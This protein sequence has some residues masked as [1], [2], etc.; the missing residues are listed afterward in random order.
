M[1]GLPTS[2]K[3]GEIFMRKIL[4]IL[5]VVSIAITILPISTVYAVSN[6]DILY[7]FEGFAGGTPTQDSTTLTWMGYDEAHEEPWTSAN[8][9]K[10][11]TWL[12][13]G[14]RTGSPSG[15]T[16]RIVTRD[17]TTSYNANNRY[18]FMSRPKQHVVSTTY[19]EVWFSFDWMVEDHNAEHSMRAYLQV[20]GGANEQKQLFT[21]GTN[22][23]L[24]T[25]AGSTDVTI[26][27]GSWHTYEMCMSS[28]EGVMFYLDGQLLNSV[29][30]VYTTQANWMFMQ[31]LNRN[32][33][34]RYKGSAMQIDDYR[35]TSYKTPQNKRLWGVTNEAFSESEDGITFSGIP[36]NRTGSPKSYFI[37]LN[38][39]DE[40]GNYVTYNSASG[41]QASGTATSPVTVTVSQWGEDYTA[42]AYV[43]N[44]VTDRTLFCDEIYHR[45]I[46]TK[47][48]VFLYK[49]FDAA[50]GGLNGF[51]IAAATGGK[52][53]ETGTESY[54][55]LSAASEKYA[56]DV[57]FSGA[58]DKLVFEAMVK[59]ENSGTNLEF[60]YVDSA[61]AFDCF[62]TVNANGSVKAG[63]TTVG[64]LRSGEW[65]RISIAT[66]FS[67]HQMTAWLNGGQVATDIGRALNNQKPIKIRIHRPES[68]TGGK[69]SIDN[70]RIYSGNSVVRVPEASNETISILG[71]DTVARS[72][73][74]GKQA[75][76]AYSSNIVVNGVKK[77]S[78]TPAFM[79]DGIIYVGQD[80]LSQ[81]LDVGLIGYPGSDVVRVSSTLMLMPHTAIE[82]DGEIYLPARELAE[83]LNRKTLQ[84]E[85]GVLLIS[86]NAFTMD[87]TTLQEVNDYMQYGRLTPDE[88]LALLSE[89]TA[90]PRTI[91]SAE[92]VGVIRNAYQTRDA[93]FMT[94]YRN[95][96]K[97]LFFSDRAV[98]ENTATSSIFWYTIS[99]ISGWLSSRDRTMKAKIWD[100]VEILCNQS[101]WDVEN[102]SLGRAH[103]TIVVAMAYDLLYDQWDDTQRKLMEDCIIEY[104]LK[105]VK[106]V[107]E[108]DNPNLTNVFAQGN[109]INAICA[110]AAIIGAAAV[111]DKAPELSSYV[112]AESMHGLERV[113]NNFYPH[114]GWG[115]GAD[116]AAYMMS[117]LPLG[118]STIENSLGHDYGFL[119][120]PGVKEQALFAI[121]TTGNCGANNY[122]DGSDWS[123]YQ[124][125]DGVSIA[126][127]AHTFESPEYYQLRKDYRNLIGVVTHPQD[128]LYYHPE[129]EN[130]AVTVENPLDSYFADSEFF[131]MRSD[132]TKEGTYLSGHFGAESVSHSHYDNGTFVL[133]MLGERWAIDLGKDDYNLPGYFVTGTRDLY[134][135]VRPEGHNTVV[136]GP[137]SSLG[138]SYHGF[139]KILQHA[140]SSDGAFVVGD[141]TSVYENA[142]SAKRGFMLTDN[143]SSVIIRDEIQTKNACDIYWF[144]HT[145]ADIEIVDS[146]TA[147]LTKNGKQITLSFITNVQNAV[148]SEMEAVPLSTSPNPDGQMKNEG[149]SKIAIRIPSAEDVD[150]TVRITPVG[151]TA[152][153]M[154]ILDIPLEQWT[155][156]K[157]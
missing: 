34:G 40:A 93:K 36:F 149:V 83:M 54:Y 46:Q 30:T 15:T 9:N 56:A 152:E 18:V 110:S 117:L 76:H 38:V 111:W 6:T 24:S 150:L 121:A 42:K 144:M 63:K 103:S 32:Y 112:M 131:S 100:A 123:T 133:D 114:G 109:N 3:I 155:V 151:S 96:L 72:N 79:E 130:N 41:T 125:N 94:L 99:F 122:H 95:G 70:L 128:I 74:I 66:D 69:V 7:D 62:L 61:N 127:A 8:L 65:N 22:G 78:L 52:L 84:G 21:I 132:Y 17:N 39:Y 35:V 58:T 81:M 116:Y 51:Q 37:V 55:E 29:S 88:V 113:Q 153:N 124:A 135:R 134:Y 10:S 102:D 44:S 20:S 137:D 14:V 129:W 118:L 154:D 77:T 142:T 80:D 139:G 71:N 5:L 91:L 87:T 12:E 107:L 119:T 147:I 97:N 28:T 25:L 68:T 59:Q 145:S 45:N 106:E 67:S 50:T 101:S 104:G 92:Q 43:Q 31:T 75:V 16:M 60:Y 73:L 115:E 2:D 13:P 141:M 120:A 105:P 98:D 1:I 126:W 27:T 146:T 86:D 33:R 85:R 49:N 156:S 53:V 143:R 19:P 148:L 157:N 26:S 108:G 11:D 138:H 136:I 90:H 48:K 57:A 64:T 23:K 82:K 47:P 89:H 4:S 140:S